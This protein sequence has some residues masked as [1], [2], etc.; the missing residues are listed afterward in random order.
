MM[1][2]LSAT[3]IVHEVLC[4]AVFVT[5]FD[6]LVKT[7]QTTIRP[8]RVAIWFMGMAAIVSAFAPPCWGYSPQWPAVLVLLAILVVQV[9]TAV[10]W[11]HGVPHCFR[12]HK[13]D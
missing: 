5:C 2:P 1:L 8:I 3:L 13:H 11:R 4:V 7:D 12:S 9:T 10:Y 6:R